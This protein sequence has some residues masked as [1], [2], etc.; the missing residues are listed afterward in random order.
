MCLLDEWMALC[1][2]L[3]LRPRG[4]HQITPFL[5]SLPRHRGHTFK[6]ICPKHLVT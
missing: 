6:V 3:Y 1:I 4:T 5:S 2:I